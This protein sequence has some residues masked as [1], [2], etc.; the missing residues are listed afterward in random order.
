M[1]LK[2]SQTASTTPNSPTTTLPSTPSQLACMILMCIHYAN[3][4]QASLM[5]MIENLGQADDEDSDHD[6]SE[7]S[8]FREWQ[9]DG[10][11]ESENFSL[12]EEDDLELKN[13]S[14]DDIDL[15]TD[16]Q[17]CMT[18]GYGS[19][20][21]DLVSSIT[22]NRPNKLPIRRPKPRTTKQ[23]ITP[24]QIDEALYYSSAKSKSLHDFDGHSLCQPQTGEADVFDSDVEEN[25]WQADDEDSDHD[26]SEDSDFREWQSDGSENFSLD[27]ENDLELENES[28][29]D[30]DLETDTQLYMTLGHGSIDDDL[31]RPNKLP[32][33]RPKPRTAKQSITPLQINEALPKLRTIKQSITPLQINEALH[34]NLT[35]S[36]S[37]DDVFDRDVEENLGQADDEDNDHDDSEDSNFREWQSDGSEESQNFSLDEGDDLELENESLDDI[38]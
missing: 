2:R 27:E 1:P 30:I 15:E 19:I 12:D 8:D 21:D 31:D 20:D 16:T 11:E 28:L 38:D 24:L 3:H 4:K 29:D 35:K 9:S 6:D 33:G 36:K 14:L 32:I 7:D 34:Y 23:P 37:E 18:L 10:S 13:E 22:I 5:R 25:L 17:L 26:Y